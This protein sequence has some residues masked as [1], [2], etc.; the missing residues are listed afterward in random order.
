MGDID[1]FKIVKYTFSLLAFGV[2][3]YK[4][5]GWARAKKG[6]VLIDRAI[7][8]M[9]QGN[10]RQALSLYEQGVNQ[11]TPGMEKHDIHFHFANECVRADLHEKG[12]ELALRG[13]A[14]SPQSVMG[15]LI[16]GSARFS[17]GK[18]IGAA[19]SFRTVTELDTSNATAWASLG[20][21]SIMLNKP[22]EAVPFYQ[23]ALELDQDKG[24]QHSNLAMAYARM[25]DVAAAERH[26]N[27][28]RKAGYDN[29]KAVEEEVAAAR[30]EVADHNR[31]LAD[32]GTDW[33]EFKSRLDR[34]AE[35]TARPVMRL[36]PRRERC[37][38]KD[39]RFAG[40][41]W[42]PIGFAIPQDGGGHE[43]RLL[44]QINLAQM[45]ALEGFPRKGILQF[46][47]ADDDATGLDFDGK[48]GYAGYRVVYHEDDGQM[49]AIYI[50]AEPSKPDS[51]PITCELKLHFEK[52]AEPV[53]V[54]D[55][56][57][58]ELF[59]RHVGFAFSSLSAG[60]HDMISERF[61]GGGH[62]LGGYPMFTQGDPRGI[63][64]ECARYDTLLLQIDSDDDAGIMWGDC[65][66][67]NFFIP[68]TALAAGKFDDVL[69]T[70]DCC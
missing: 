37:A 48:A 47:V 42:Q 20:T 69:Y 5:I 13:L 64:G 7:K 23:K 57:F 66:V 11:D 24:T 62:K 15:Y 58:G 40:R 67:A 45:P 46:Y 1:W 30:K 34:L 33:A 52:D 21:I 10:V 14:L 17:Q 2:A 9:K 29:I 41:P 3:V 26:V 50:P 51:F 44:A 12:E 8:A 68:A 70:W 27:L 56:R 18:Y 38:A 32:I 16:L 49:E 65:G 60:L 53:S 59:E 43:L 54:E 4:L 35:A 63:S 22:A 61:S 39:S 25:R 19:E 36:L 28:A 55:F 6:T 31:A